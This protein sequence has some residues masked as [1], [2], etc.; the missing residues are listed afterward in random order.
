MS[1]S[2]QKNLEWLDKLTGLRAQVKKTP[3]A[4]HGELA[5]ALDL[6]R[7][8]V[9]HLYAL[10]D[11]LDQAAEDKIQQAAEGKNPYLLSFNNAKI[12]A[13]LNGKID[14]LPGSFH[15]ILDVII[16][17]RFKTRHIENLVDWVIAGHPAAEFDPLKQQSKRQ[18]TSPIAEPELDTEEV[19]PVKEVASLKG[20]SVGQRLDGAVEGVRVWAAK[21]KKGLVM[22]GVAA[23]L[24]LW[25][26]RDTLLKTTDASLPEPVQSPI[27][28]SVQGRQNSSNLGSN[29]STQ[30]QAVSALISKG[31]VVVPEELKGRVANDA[32]IAMAFA[33]NF[34][35]VSYDTPSTQ[36]KYLDDFTNDHYTDAFFKEFY[37]K[38]KLREIRSQKLTLFFQPS[39][40]A[41]VLKVDKDSGE[42][43]VEGVATTI[44]E[45]GKTK[46]FISERPVGLIIDFDDRPS[47]NGGIVKVTET[48]PAANP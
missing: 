3:S 2:N 42:Y 26:Y 4:T 14:G 11:I 24:V 5:K 38:E 43:L 32:G 31:E 15:P 12:L 18:I 20:Q 35:G 30:N 22:V 33:V 23:V 46:K 8:T 41:K 21:Y 45:K 28:P 40:P 36:L 34:Y 19:T 7:P 9:S 47:A 17:R 25:N 1:E 39:K 48:S 29:I 44:S 37:P 13:G 10:K 27:G 6:Q 16:S